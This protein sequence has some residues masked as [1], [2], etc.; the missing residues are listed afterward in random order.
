[1]E[2]LNVNVQPELRKAERRGRA[3]RQSTPPVIV[4][5]RTRKVPAYALLSEDA[6]QAIENQ[7]DWIL[8]HIGIEF[9]GDVTALELFAAAGATVAGERVTFAPG[10]ARHLCSTVP[11]EFKLHARDPANTVTLGGDN[12]VLMPGYGSPFVSD[13]EQGRRYATLAD[14]ENF[15]KLT[16]SSPWL[17]HSGGTVCEPTDIPVNKRHLDMVFAHLT[18]STERLPADAGR[19]PF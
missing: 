18:L 17:H 6:L 12:V 1:M 16:Y 2:N 19:F 8:E 11:A 4:S 15:V 3:A 9:R 14:F 5:P 10:L 13:L 7:A